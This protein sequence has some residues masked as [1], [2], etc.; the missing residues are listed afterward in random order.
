MQVVVIEVN[1]MFGRFDRAWRFSVSWFGRINLT[2]EKMC[3]EKG[4]KS[5]HSRDRQRLIKICEYC[6][7]IQAAVRIHIPPLKIR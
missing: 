4:G 3:G 7:D 2:E 6:E 5:M 1:A